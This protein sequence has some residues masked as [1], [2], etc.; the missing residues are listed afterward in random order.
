MSVVQLR[1]TDRFALVELAG[2]LAVE[3]GLLNID[4]ELVSQAVSTA[5][6]AWYYSD[7]TLTEEQRGINHVKAYIDKHLHR[8]VPTD[9][10]IEANQDNVG[11][12]KGSLYLLSQEHLDK[13]CNGVNPS[14]VKRALSD[15][16]FLH[17]QSSTNDIRYTSRFQIAG[18]EKRLP[19]YAIK[20]CILSGEEEELDVSGDDE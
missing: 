15:N 12:K 17:T 19:F 1:I 2:L 16:H 11:F 10:V 14:I 20:S 9:E 8:F 6:S 18:V 13:A 7:E 5:H 4:A 3:F